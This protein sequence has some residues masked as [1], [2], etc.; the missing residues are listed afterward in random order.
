M[1]WAAATATRFFPVH[2][3]NHSSARQT[4]HAPQ[5]G[6]PPAHVQ[7]RRRA[8]VRRRDGRDEDWVADGQVAGLRHEVA[9]GR[10]HLLNRPALAVLVAVEDELV[11]LR[12]PQPAHALAVDLDRPEFGVLHVEHDDVVLLGLVLVVDRL[13]HAQQRRAVGHH[14]VSPLGLALV[15][16]D[17]VLGVLLHYAVLLVQVRVLLG[18]RDVVLVQLQGHARAALDELQQRKV[19][20]DPLVLRRRDA[21]VAAEHLVER[22]HEVVARHREARRAGRRQQRA[23]RNERQRKAQTQQPRREEGRARVRTRE[24]VRR[25]VGVVARGLGSLGRGR[26]RAAGFI[27]REHIGRLSRARG[28]VLAR[29]E[30]ERL[31]RAAFAVP[32]AGLDPPRVHLLER[33]HRDAAALAVVVD[34]VGRKDEVARDKGVRQGHQRLEQL[35]GRQPALEL[36]RLNQV[37]QQRRD[38]GFDQRLTHRKHV[39]HARRR[40]ERDRVGLQHGRLVQDLPRAPAHRPPRP[41]AEQRQP[42]L[43]ER[44]PDAALVVRRVLRDRLELALLTV[45][46]LEL[47]PAQLERHKAVAELD[48]V[49]HGR[50][51]V[52][53]QDKHVAVLEV[54]AVPP[55]LD[56]VVQRLR[57]RPGQVLV[58]DAVEVVE[59]RR[60]AAVERVGQA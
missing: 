8:R 28:R 27:R 13:A 33:R 1:F 34:V 49:Q 9:D 3:T 36:R 5:L 45:R 20:E 37:V 19:A 10:A 42:V 40:V 38:K 41:E 60:R 56:V 26:R 47:E 12:R 35:V 16:D 58:E 31:A 14:G 24:E 30:L 43:A 11:L 7:R 54:A 23:P 32:D 57:E 15:A 25:P 39:E 21:H 29:V 55:V 22:V 4:D 17:Q 59:R 2:T 18:Q 46:S 52:A 44:V 6:R 51:L 50:E 48:D 53:D